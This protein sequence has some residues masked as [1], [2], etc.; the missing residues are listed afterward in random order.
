MK[1]NLHIEWRRPYNHRIYDKV[2]RV[3][4]GQSVSGEWFEDKPRSQRRLL[5]RRGL[6]N[7]PQARS[8]AWSQCACNLNVSAVCS[9]ILMLSTIPELQITCF[10]KESVPIKSWF[11]CVIP[12]KI[13]RDQFFALLAR[14]QHVNKVGNGHV[15]QQ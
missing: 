8:P 10:G 2:S 14:G 4:K 13:C 11:H 15:F 5:R 6:G 9:R 3:K 1:G 7:E 12:S